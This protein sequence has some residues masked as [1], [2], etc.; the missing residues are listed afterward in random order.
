MVA[1]I[2]TGLVVSLAYA[3]ALAGFDTDERLGRARD[4]AESEAIAR[5]LIGSALRHALPGVRGGDPVFELSERRIDGRVSDE[6][7]FL[8][9][10]VIEPHGAGGVWEMSLSTDAEGL[11]IAARPLED[12]GT[13][14]IAAVLPDVRVLDVQVRGRDARQGWLDAWVSPDRSPVAVSIAWSV[15]DGRAAGAPLTV[16]IGLEGNP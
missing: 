14:P 11:R 13:L 15:A 3:A 8:T 6:V 2:V 10:G 16:R 1:L 12:D 7:R 9:R 4:G 5:A